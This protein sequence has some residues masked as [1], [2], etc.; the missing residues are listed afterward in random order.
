M[1]GKVF[2]NIFP[3]FLNN[4]PSSHVSSR[5]SEVRSTEQVAK[6]R[7]VALAIKKNATSHRQQAIK[8]WETWNPTKLFSWTRERDEGRGNLER[9]ENV[10]RNT[11]TFYS[12]GFI[13]SYTF[14]S[15][16]GMRTKQWFLCFLKQ[17]GVK[18]EHGN[19]SWLLPLFQFHSIKRGL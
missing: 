1:L 18:A 7:L 16:G 19:V 12:P 5:G 9:L 6:A 17:G 3:A 11:F 8:I 2:Y 14:K 13:A 4:F 10:F 15:T